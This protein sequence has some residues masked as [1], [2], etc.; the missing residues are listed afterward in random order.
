M[1]Y[2][3]GAGVFGYGFGA[4]RDGV[5]GQLT[6]QKETDS[7]LDFPTG[8]GASLVVVGEARGFGSNAFEDVVHERVH[9]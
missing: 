5:F 2:L 1:N 6:R 7:G 4:F 8:D 3:L 9:D